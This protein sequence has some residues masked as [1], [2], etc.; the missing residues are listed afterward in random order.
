MRYLGIDYG[1]KRIGLAVSDDAGRF[2]VPYDV[3]EE[4][5]VPDALVRLQDIVKREQITDVIVGLP[6]SMA[7]RGEANGDM[8]LTDVANDVMQR[9]LSFIHD[10]RKVISLPVFTIDERLST[11]EADRRMRGIKHNVRAP[12]D[13]VAA[14]IIL[15]SY[16]DSQK[17][18][19]KES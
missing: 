17:Q 2:A 14:S 9:V 12:R 13:A 5:S 6:L 3:I 7:P 1:E 4:E 19:I 18:T 15:Q 10:V 11:V 16:L 8:R